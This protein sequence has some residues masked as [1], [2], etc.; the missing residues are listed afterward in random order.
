MSAPARGLAFAAALM[1]PTA[2][3]RAEPDVLFPPAT[4]SCYVG[5]E[6]APAAAGAPR[7]RKP[8]V[9]V[10]AVR[11]ERGYPQLAHEER[12]PPR[13]EGD[14]LINLRVIV[15]FADAGKRGAP[16]RY[17]NGPNDLLRCSADLCDAN[18]YKVERQAD[19]TV[20]LRMTGGLYVGASTYDDKANRH[21]PDRHVYRL[22][23]SP[24]S[25]CR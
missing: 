19:G 7:Y 9:P 21:L 2:G 12:E 1:L 22:A 13:Q 3:A 20:L 25:A 16:L 4:A 6:I 17:A 10:T 23:A 24:M 18:N 15:T 8:S 14:R 11:L 5:A